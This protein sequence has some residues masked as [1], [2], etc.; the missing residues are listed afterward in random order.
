MEASEKL[1]SFDEEKLID[2]VKNYR[3]YGYSD[4]I[5]NSALDVLESRG[6]DTGILKLRGDLTNSNYDEAKE[7]FGSFERN[8]GIAFV[9]Y[10]L[11]LVFRFITSF[12]G[13]SEAVIITFLILFWLSFIG[14][15]VYL[16]RS[17]INQSRY[18]KIVGKEN[19]QINP[20]LYFTV[21]LIIYAV[22]YFMF[23]KQMRNEM[24][25]IR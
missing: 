18:Y 16:I 14:F 17:F 8:S 13:D 22:M 20:G 10:G 23:R 12:A 3:Q 2:I 9:L 11:L 15:V 25:E 7:E 19:D 5:R 24:N 1:K 4:E 21:G 6:I